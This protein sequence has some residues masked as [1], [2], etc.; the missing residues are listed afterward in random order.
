MGHRLGK[1]PPVE[2]HPFEEVADR[3]LETIRSGGHV[4]QRWNCEHCGA[5]Q[6]MPIP[7][8][9]WQRGICEECGKETDIAAHGCNFTAMFGMDEG[10][11]KRV[12]TEIWPD[13][14]QEEREH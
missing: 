13:V 14:N 4:F 6:T 11:L 10:L 3:A 1:E 12:L 7:N 2:L 5:G 8:K 9:F